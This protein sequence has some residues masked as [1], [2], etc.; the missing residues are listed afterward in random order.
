MKKLIHPLLLL[1]A[2]ATEKEATKYIEYLKA[3]NKILR[4]KLP[5]RVEVTEAEKAT[6]IKLG[7]AV[8]TAIK[9]LISIVHPRTFAR[10]VS[11]KKSGTDKEKK[12]RGRPRKPEEVRQMVIDFAKDTGWGFRRIWG[13][14]QKL[15]IKCMSRSTVARV[16]KE[17]G[18]D[19]GPKRGSGTWN[20]F[21]QRHIKTLWATDFF[22]KTVMTLKGPV[23]Y[24][25]LFFIHLHSRRVHLAG[26]TPNPNGD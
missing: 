17:N 15:G 10:W 6:L 4:S 12:P 22:T 24:Y 16:L 8:G 19:P 25:V 3:E 23:T 9:E 14:L 7:Q 18:F 11:E 21:V 13:E 5:K 2:K 20:E 1:L 26:M